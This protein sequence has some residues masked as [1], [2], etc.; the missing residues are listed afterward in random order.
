MPKPTFAYEP[1]GAKVKTLL[2]L[3]I[4]IG[5][6]MFVSQ[7]NRSGQDSAVMT[8]IISM[9]L[10][11]PVQ[12]WPA[13]QLRTTKF[14]QPAIPWQPVRASKLVQPANSWQPMWPAKDRYFKQ[15][16]NA[17]VRAE[18]ESPAPAEGEKKGPSWRVKAV[19]SMGDVPEGAIGTATGSPVEIRWDDGYAISR[20]LRR[21]SDYER[22][23][24]DTPYPPGGPK[25]PTEK[26]TTEMPT[27][28]PKPATTKN[29]EKEGE[30]FKLP[31][32]K[33]P[34]IKLPFSGD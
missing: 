5:C 17:K 6:A 9:G 32:L 25:A 7:V 10:A 31:E 33:L 4:G 16:W 20:D 26:P 15:L 24:D 28:K 19:K 12:S 29:P 11:Q 1:L 34:E 13:Q 3:L 18:G 23:S 27:P 22:I 21:G 8:P 30:G 2:C 14:V